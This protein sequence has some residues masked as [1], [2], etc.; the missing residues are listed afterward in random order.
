MR[1]LYAYLSC[2]CPTVG[3]RILD[4]GCGCGVG[5]L[6][7]PERGVAEAVGV[8]LDIGT[9]ETNPFYDLARR[10][11]IPTK[12][13]QL[14]QADVG[15]LSGHSE[16]FDAAVSMDVV[17]HVANLEKFLGNVF[18]A[19]KPGGVAVFECGALYYADTG[20]HLSGYFDPKEFP[21]VHLYHDLPELL[22]RRGVS[23]WTRREI[24]MLNRLT[25]GRL[26]ETICKAGFHIINECVGESSRGRLDEFRHRIDF[27]QVPDQEDLFR[28]WTRIAA[29]RPV[30]VSASLDEETG[31]VVVE[32]AD[33]RTMRGGGPFT[34]RPGIAVS[35]EAVATVAALGP[36]KS[37]WTG[38]CYLRDHAWGLWRS[39]I[40]SFQG[41]PAVAVTPGGRVFVCVRD[42]HGGLWIARFDARTGYEPMSYLAGVFVSD[43]S[44]VATRE[45]GVHV[46]ATDGSNLVWWGRYSEAGHFAGWNHL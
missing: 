10:F 19:L 26:R 45:G 24:G 43:P 28:Q 35:N 11:E 34:G 21:W 4:A 9:P 33:G 36:D 15:T 2:F 30:P 3:A 18:D 27:S 46:W 13:L 23:A 42:D 7:A 1:N 37:L 38:T 17:E 12:N 22:D 16:Y 14:V 5:L 44:L 41:A 32:T 6:A 25:Y 29:Q 40:G 39:T 8:D 31:E 20:G